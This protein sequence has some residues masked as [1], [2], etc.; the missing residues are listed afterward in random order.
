MVKMFFFFMDQ[1]WKHQRSS[2]RTS[3]V[4][5]DQAGEAGLRWFGHV[6]RRNSDCMGG[7]MLGLEQSKRKNKRV[8]SM[9]VLSLFFS[10]AA[11]HARL[12]VFT[13]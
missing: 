3:D 6:Q 5:G 7:K 12:A 9:S 10:T 13:L 1:G 2:E 8:T 11:V 4:F